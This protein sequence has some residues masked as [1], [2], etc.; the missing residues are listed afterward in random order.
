LERSEKGGEKKERGKEERAGHLMTW[1]ARKNRDHQGGR[2]WKRQVAN[3]PAT[4]APDMAVKKVN[5]AS[6]WTPILRG[7]GTGTL[8]TAVEEA[9]GTERDMAVQRIPK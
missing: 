1:K 9:G 6:I 5:P 2:R 7:R 3:V 8:T 4:K